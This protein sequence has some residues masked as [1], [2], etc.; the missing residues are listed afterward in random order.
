MARLSIALLGPLRLQLDGEPV[1]GFESDKVRALLAYLA[2]ESDRPIPRQSLTGLLWPERPERLARHD[3]SQALYNLRS[4]LG[5]QATA[6][7]FIIVTRQTVQFNPLSDHWLDVTAFIGLIEACK[8]HAHRRLDLCEPCIERL[9]QL[10]HIYEGDVL[11]GFYCDDSLPFEEWLFFQRERFHQL[12]VNG[13]RNL[14]RCHERRGEHRQALTYARHFVALEPYDEAAHRQMMRA[15]AATG[16]RNMALRQYKACHRFLEAELGVEPEEETRRLYHRIRHGET[17]LLPVALD[18]HNL[19]APINPLVGRVAELAR[20]KERLRA[21]DCRLL[22]LVGPGGI[23]KTRLAIEACSDLVMSDVELVDHTLPFPDGI[24]LVPLASLR[25]SDAVVPAVARAIGVSFSAEDGLSQP[26]AAAPSPKRQ[27]LDTLRNRRT[28]L[29]LDGFEHLLDGAGL[30]SEILHAGPG[31]KILVTSRIRLDVQGECLHRVSPLQIPDAVGTTLLE[32]DAIRRCSAVALFTT[33]ARRV[34]PGFEA[35]G[36]ELRQV[37]K[38]SRLVQG[39]PLAILLAAAWM[40]TLSPEQIAAQI[41]DRSVDFLCADWPDVPERQR[42][43]RAVLDWS[44]NLLDQQQRETLAKLSVFH[45]SF[46][47]EAA[48]QVVGASQQG[49]EGL[50]RRS[51]LSRMLVPVAAVIPPRSLDTTARQPA[52]DGRYEMHEILKQYAAERLARS[53]EATYT[54]R[55]RHADYYIGILQQWLEDAQGPH[56][57]AALH[58]MDSDIH[59]ARG[60]WDWLVAQ[61]DVTGIRQ[62]VDGLCWFYRRRSRNQEAVTACQMAMERLS[63]LVDREDRG[64]AEPLRLLIRV[65]VWQSRFVTDAEAEALTVQALDLLDLAERNDLDIRWEKAAALRRS[66]RARLRSDPQEA[67][68]RLKESLM[69]FRDVEDR[70]EETLTLDTMGQ[71]ALMS[72]DFAA[73]QTYH[74]QHLTLAQQSGN[75]NAQALALRGLGDIAREMGD[76][77]EGARLTRASLVLFREIGNIPAA[78]TALHNLGNQNLMTGAFDKALAMY[79]E[80]GAL[81]KDLGQPNI[82][83]NTMR[84]TVLMLTGRYT[85]ARRI[86]EACLQD[87]R[88]AGITYLE[89]WISMLFC[90]LELVDGSVDRAV[91]CSN[92]S[93]DIYR[94]QGMPWFLAF[95]LGF[96]GCALV[97]QGKEEAGTRRLVETLSI[98]AKLHSPHALDYALAGLVLLFLRRGRITRAVEL[99]AF[100]QASSAAGKSQ[101]FSDVVDATYKAAIA[102]LAAETI[103]DATARGRAMNSEHLTTVLLQELGSSTSPPN[104]TTALD[105]E[106]RSAS[107]FG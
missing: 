26:G 63:V 33:S 49:L 99:Y 68:S 54:S 1:I 32:P 17:G 104:L 47:G 95:A 58:Q 89:A 97:A 7:P 30:V 59:D 72:G 57:V 73:A 19:P 13:L 35:V 65:M 105:A 79:E 53:S 93:V 101:W 92:L 51:L 107:A 100:A 31:I 14:V 50:V 9:H 3:L 76:Y 10:I 36:D 28:L 94:S 4:T 91:K 71:A 87:V 78:A 90:G 84:T 6:P 37:A 85:E 66:A 98:G 56:Q 45:G 102:G 62:A 46:T 80:F 12:A 106:S 52:E 2:L 8:Q 74:E 24:Y 82:R 60:A 81:Y 41:A 88:D 23:G 22:T 67:M 69:L 15:L 75:L 55:R 70:W 42:S 25:S 96:S 16:Q 86:G 48:R 43:M 11:E 40:E 20:I 64:V 21:P 103:A 39:M 38:I 77:Q 44:W 29:V 5:D 61:D 83:P 18:R 34:Q 27:L